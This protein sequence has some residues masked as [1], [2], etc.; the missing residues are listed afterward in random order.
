MI[1][2]FLIA[3]ALSSPGADDLV[4]SA[5]RP[6]KGA[7]FK[8]NSLP[9]AVRNA[10]GPMADAGEAFQYDDIIRRDSHDH[11]LP[12]QQLIYA[13]QQPDGWI[14]YSIHGGY[15]PGCDKRQIKV[16]GKVREVTKPSHTMP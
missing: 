16:D 1:I 10:L 15:A 2:P 5:P 9:A 7:V 8:V 11:T 6:S 3:A 14:V 13:E 4:C 12:S